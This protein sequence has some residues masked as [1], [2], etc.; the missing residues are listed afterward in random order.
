MLRGNSMPILKGDEQTPQKE[1]IGDSNE[2]NSGLEMPESESIP[3]QS[4]RFSLPIIHLGDL[5]EDETNSDEIGTNKIK[6]GDIE[7]TKNDEEVSTKD[8]DVVTDD[9]EITTKVITTKDIKT[10]SHQ[11]I[12][13]GDKDIKDTGSTTKKGFSFK[14]PSINMPKLASKSKKKNNKKKEKK[15]N[16]KSKTDEET[17]EETKL[18]LQESDI[19][20]S[21]EDSILESSVETTRLDIAQPGELEDVQMSLGLNNDQNISYQK[22]EITQ[23]G[24]EELTEIKPD[25]NIDIDMLLEKENVKLHSEDIQTNF[26]DVD[27]SDPENKKLQKKG[28]G[29]HLPNIKSPSFKL[30]NFPKGKQKS[31]GDISSPDEKKIRNGE[32]ER[33]TDD[34]V[35]SK[36]AKTSK[37]MQIQEDSIEGT[38]EISIVESML[39][40]IPPDVDEEII[41]PTQDVGVVESVPDI[42]YSISKFSEE[43]AK[44]EDLVSNPNMNRV[45]I[46]EEVLDISESKDLESIPNLN[47][48]GETTKR[49]TKETFTDFTNTHSISNQY[50]QQQKASTKELQTNKVELETTEELQPKLTDRESD[51]DSE[52]EK[53]SKKGF[54]F[55]LPSIKPPSFNLPK[56]GG[57]KDQEIIEDTEN[58]E[59]EEEKEPSTKEPKT[60]KVELET[61]EELKAE[62][63]DEESDD[64]SEKKKSPRNGFGFNLPSIKGPSFHLPKFGG[65]KDGK[66][67]EKTG[68]LEIEEEEKEPSTK[69]PNINKDEFENTEELKAELTDGENNDDSEEKKSPRKGFGFNFQSLVVKRMEKTL[70]TL[71]TLKLK[72]KK[73]L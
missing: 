72:K 20:T 69:E 11:E 48:P 65:K 25:E 5:G 7:V 19:D 29:F 18:H 52:K 23:P 63:T 40:M 38:N 32:K 42:E 1:V 44:N 4:I 71:K 70:K 46:E 31:P 49:T 13:S 30:P 54:G 37:S 9:A 39:D 33:E 15:P 55:N 51:D 61:T 21:N 67:I 53:S 26:E 2:E 6:R 68:K 14:L 24:K 35:I 10:T 60:N 28:F 22:L 45:Q 62:L 17:E 64:D 16:N 66:D 41:V 12:D 56:F 8:D 3:K 57:K 34:D 43:E 27:L 47:L 50:S 58:L 59:I 73:S 36:A